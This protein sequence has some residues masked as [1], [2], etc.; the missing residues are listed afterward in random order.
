M[1]ATFAQNLKDAA[2]LLARA[3]DVTL[4][5]HVRP[6]ADALGSALALGRALHLRGGVKVRVS[7]G[8][9]EEMPETLRSLDV[10]GL[11]VPASELPESEQLLVALDTSTL[12][13]LGKLAPRVDAVRAA[14]GEVLVIDHHA[15][16]T[17][18]G[19]RHVVDD[20]AEATTVLVFALLE[21]MGAEIDEPIARCLYAGLVT[22]TS[23]FRRARPATHLMA[24]RLLETGVDPDKIMREIVDDHP[25]AWLPM[26]AEVLAGA[27]LEPEAAQGFGL[28]YAVVT[29]DVGGTVRAEEIE[30]VIDVVR[31]T[32]EAGVAVVLKE[33][34]PTGPGQRWQ[35]SLRSAGGVDVAAAA[36][37]LG[38]G[39]HRQAAGCTAEGTADEVLDRLRTALSRAP[40]L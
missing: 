15:S 18:F 27:R 31:S 4:L 12:G 28:A 20:T 14:G 33:A 10:D 32:R 40:L 11:Y 29:R 36:G 1:T 24:A 26:L 9:P 13:R 34:E 39:G 23:G 7:F 5:G 2:A 30:A 19:T 17:F 35:I 21:E 16:N 8:E 22:D 38:G 37:E 25:F 3:N 6:D